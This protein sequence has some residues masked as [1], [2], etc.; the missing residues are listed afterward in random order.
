[1]VPGSMLIVEGCSSEPVGER[2][3][4]ESGL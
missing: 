4:A 3:H 2:V 1:V